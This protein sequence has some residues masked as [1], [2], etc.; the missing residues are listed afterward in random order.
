[1]QEQELIKQCKKRSSNA[2]RLLYIQYASK[3]KAVCMRYFK[4]PEDVKDAMQEGFIEIFK[5]IDSYQGNG[6]FEG[7]LKRV[8]FTTCIDLIRRRKKWAVEPLDESFEMMDQDTDESTCLQLLDHAYYQ[9][10]LL[11]SLHNLPTIL[12]VVFNLYYVD[13]LSHKEIAKL[14]EINEITSRT[15]LDRARKLVKEYLTNLLNN[16]FQN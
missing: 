4:Y 1:M 9:E 15:R 13:D 14:L 2:Q 8:M 11:Q 7:W 6:S 12:S 3:L 5:S 16:E 10:H